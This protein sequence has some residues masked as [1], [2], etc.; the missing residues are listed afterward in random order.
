MIHSA[1]EF[2]ALRR[3]RQI[4]SGGDLLRLALGYGPR[5]LSLRGAAVLIAAEK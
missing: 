4:K 2:G 3:R 1:E 5:G